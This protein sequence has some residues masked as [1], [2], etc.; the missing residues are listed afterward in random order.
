[1]NPV[2][3][4]V[5]QVLVIEDD[6]AIRQLLRTTLEAEGHAVHEAATARDGRTLAGNRRIDVYLVDLGLPDGDGVALIRELRGWTQRP[7]LVLSARTQEAQ[8]VEALDAG[9]DD[10]VTKPF[11]VAEL[12][13][14]LRV[15]LRHASQTTLEG[16]AAL[17]VGPATVDLSAKTVQR[18]GEQVHLTA[19]Q[20]RLLEV[21]CRHAGRVVTARQLLREVWGPGHA[22]Q[23]HY[24]RIYIR[25]LRQKLEADPA[26]PVHLVTETGVGYRLVIDNDSIG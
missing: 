4:R 23:A 19:T 1:M 5:V 20:W 7:I 2:R 16:E 9:A 24:L 6:P 18:D 22:D 3:P 14:R 25:Q 10:F 8:K 13:A 21:L 17:T 15:A 12:H 11:G 26:H